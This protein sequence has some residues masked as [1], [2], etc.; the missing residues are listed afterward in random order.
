MVLSGLV[1][2]GLG[3]I[4]LRRRAR[5]LVIIALLA[6]GF[7]LLAYFAIQDIFTLSGRLQ[8]EADI[9]DS[10]TMLRLAVDIFSARASVYQ[11]C[12]L[13]IAAVW[14]FSVLDTWRIGRRLR[15]QETTNVATSK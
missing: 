1:L 5:G 15:S 12:L 2:P 10:R 4:F 14:I 3:Q 8:M 13:Y 7:V 9:L 11:G 6:V